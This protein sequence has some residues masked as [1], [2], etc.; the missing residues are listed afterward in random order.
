MHP[1]LPMSGS[2]YVKQDLCFDNL[3]IYVSWLHAVSV[4]LCRFSLG[5]ASGDY[6]LVPVLG[7]LIVMASL[8]VDGAQALELAGFSSFDTWV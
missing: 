1:N 3:S 5:V 6:Y 2:C 8:A 4:A 7:L